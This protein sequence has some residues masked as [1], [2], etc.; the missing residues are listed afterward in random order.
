MG[1]ADDVLLGLA[2]IGITTVIVS[3]IR[4][5][6]NRFLKAFIG[7]SVDSMLAKIVFS[8]DFGD[9]ERETLQPMKKKRYC[10][11]PQNMFVRFGMVTKLLDKLEDRN[12]STY[13]IH[14]T[15]NDCNY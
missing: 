9:L 12:T 5:G 1:W 2:P 8:V 15:I 3:A 11:P 13:T 4:I 14:R 10:L 6:N 7:R